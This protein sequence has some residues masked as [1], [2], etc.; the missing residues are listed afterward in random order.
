M[1]RLTIFLLL[2]TS[3]AFGQDCLQ[4]KKDKKPDGS[5]MAYNTLPDEVL[6]AKYM[7]A[8]DTTYFVS[9]SVTG[10]MAEESPKGVVFFFDKIDPK[11]Y[12]DAEV[13]YRNINGKH[14]YTVTV[15]V[16][17]LDAFWLAGYQL[18]AVKVFVFQKDYSQAH[19]LRFRKNAECVIGAK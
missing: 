18:A 4:I 3:L 12:P 14:T 8:S 15:Q 17:P 7:T 16:K 9:L 13:G 10:N 19:Q 6:L 1:K 11:K 5:I 2:I